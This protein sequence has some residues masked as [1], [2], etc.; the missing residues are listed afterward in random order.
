VDGL[1][2]CGGA[3]GVL[4]IAPLVPHL[5]P[6]PALVLISAFLIVSAVIAQFAPR[7]RNEALEVVSP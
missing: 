5:D 2:V 4:V 7:T 6:L 1:G 3:V